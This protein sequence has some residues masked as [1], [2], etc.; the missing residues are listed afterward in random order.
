MSQIQ[1]I[2]DANNIVEIIGERLNLK[3]AGANYKALCPFHNEKTPSFVVSD[4]MQ[5]YKC[6]GCGETGDVI[7]FLE[8]Y[9]NITFIE[10]LKFLAER[11][12]IRLQEFSKSS[13]DEEREQLFEILNLAKEY[14]HFLLVKHTVGQK[15]RDYLK[16]RGINQDA[17]KLFQLGYAL[18]DW[19]GLVKYL[20]QK[21]HYPLDLI[22][23]TG[24][25]I[26]NQN[27]RFYDRFRDRLIFPLKNHR[28][29]VVGFSGRVFEKEVK[30]AKY[31]NSPETLLYHKSEMLYGYSE[32]RQDIKQA[33][34]IIVVEGEFDVIS[35][36]QA[37]VKNIVAIKGS[38]LTTEQIKLF[39][40]VADRVLLC[41]DSDQAG[42]KA[43]QRAIQ[44]IKQSRLELRVIDLN[45][46]LNSDNKNKAKI[47]HDVD[48]L[49]NQNPSLWREKAK[50]SISIYDYL[51]KV[52]CQQYDLQKAHGK[53][54]IIEDL[55]TSFNQI[56]SAVEQD[57]YL[58]KLA[59]IINVRPSVIN[60]DLK[61]LKNQ[62]NQPASTLKKQFSQSNSKQKTSSNQEM[63]LQ[64]LETYLLFL[65]LRNPASNIQTLAQS[66]NEITFS[67]LGAQQLVKEIVDFQAQFDLKKLSSFLAEDLKIKLFDWYHNPKYE[68]I[69]N[70][71][72]IKKEWQQTLKKL[73][74]ANIKMQINQL[75]Q[76]LEKIDQKFKKNPKDEEIINQL[77][78]KI[79]QLQK[80]LNK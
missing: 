28:G 73:Q 26:E 13:L 2:K 29:L 37:H 18:A 3:A 57:F 12:G 33:K 51:I 17:I 36:F 77:L 31:I 68:Q 69:L 72:N 22:K 75:N 19:E 40:R 39:E 41:F 60:Q 50:Q 49:A 80:K 53:R 34:T 1:A 38:A 76:K 56:S 58:K 4:T 11:A 61:R 42:I 5:R 21:K 67:S 27:Q 14:Y 74:Q 46:S 15:A 66:L 64:Q 23:K 54:Q 47:Y 71:I 32:L 8:K 79:T 78:V 48:D 45:Q 7:N 24:L 59:S 30:E 10:A 35:S 63:I 20:H 44:L 25:I 62:H 70:Q 65:L 6:F 9:E 43:S 16:A 55:A 52:I